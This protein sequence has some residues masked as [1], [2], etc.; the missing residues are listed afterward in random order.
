LAY[1][2]DRKSKQNIASG[3]QVGLSSPVNSFGGV[4]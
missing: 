3:K 1:F 2:R 4:R